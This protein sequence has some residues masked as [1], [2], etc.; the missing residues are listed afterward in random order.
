MSDHE[1]GPVASEPAQQDDR[2]TDRRIGR[3]LRTVAA[4]VAGLKSPSRRQIV[5]GS[6]AI[7][8]MAVV[9]G[10]TA[11]LTTGGGNAHADGTPPVNPA[12]TEIARD[13]L[14]LDGNGT[15]LTDTYLGLL[16]GTVKVTSNPQR[17]AVVGAGIAGLALADML[18]RAGHQV[19]LVEANTNRIGG[20]IK[21]IRSW[22]QPASYAEAG[23]MRIPDNHRL[24]MTLA[25][26]LGVGVRPFI[27]TNGGR[28][29]TVNGATATRDA[30]DKNPAVINATF[31]PPGWPT[32]ITSTARALLDQAFKPL[33]DLVTQ[34]PGTT[35]WERLITEYDAFSLQRYLTDKAAYSA[36]QVDLIGTLES[37]TARMYLS[38]LHSFINARQLA[39]DVRFNEVI[40]GTDRL[41]DALATRIKA[42]DPKAFVQGWR[43]IRVDSRSTKIQLTL[44]PENDPKDE[45]LLEADHA[46]LAVPF[47]ALRYVDFTPELTPGKRRAITELHYSEATKVLLEFHENWWGGNGGTD[48]TDSPLRYTAYPSHP[49]GNGGVILASYTSADDAALWDSLPE[50]IRAERALTLLAAEHGRQVTTTYTGKWATQSWAVDPYAYG[51]GAVYTPGQALEIGPD[52][53]TTEADGR[54]WFAGDHT[55]TQYR[56][57]IEGALESAC[58]VAYALGTRPEDAALTVTTQ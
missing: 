53:R 1:D 43:L 46:I 44:V 9:G 37:L 41:P 33:A 17:I 19:R 58:R 39:P 23:A 42:K 21:T 8:G 5:V 13:I 2:Q 49:S 7:T 50:P 56:T 18:Q 12:A 6:A 31:Q 25:R 26:Y 40:G 45:Q 47:P 57:W 10:I 4:G 35:G 32:P 24:A 36:P 15:D 28:S 55:S 16:T 20:R 14:R 54:L 11:A 51:E 34:K 48:I 22:T 38:V 52:T 30:Y 3:S 29:I 27:N